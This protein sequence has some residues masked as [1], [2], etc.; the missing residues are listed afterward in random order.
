MEF[1]TSA[2]QPI[3]YDSLS[4]VKL[5]VLLK[6]PFVVENPRTS[7]FWNDRAMKRNA[8][9]PGVEWIHFHMCGFRAVKNILFRGL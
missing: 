3:L 8:R 9:L 1:T 5:A 2:A 7:M 4:F 6:V